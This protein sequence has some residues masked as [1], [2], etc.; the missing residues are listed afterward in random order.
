M[1]RCGVIGVGAMGK[2][3]ARLYDKIVECELIGVADTNE[4]RANSIANLYSVKAFTDYHDLLR[5]DLSVISICTPTSL[6]CQVAIDCIKKNINCLVEKPI[7]TSIEEA[8]NMIREA[9][10]KDLKLMI[11]HIE[12]FNPAVIK[13]KEIIDKEFLGKL[14]I[15]SIK[16]VGPY[17]TRIMDVGIIVDLATHDIDISRFLLKREPIKIVAKYGKIKHLK[18]DYALIL[19]DYGDIFVNIETNWFT[20]HKIRTL[21]V[22]GTKGIA[23]LDY[24]NQNIKICNSE[25]EFNPKII[26]G[27]PLEHEIKHFIKCVKYNKTPLVSGEEGLKT[28][29]IALDCYRGQNVT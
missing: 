16:R 9:N 7:A 28:L 2:N 13:L 18:E 3:H 8:N 29:K 11:G 27:E 10:K 4:E 21:T 5:E 14:L 24:I 26:K 15:I 20:P 25:L 23:Y 22:T 12:R 6:H 19:L 1:L 17:I